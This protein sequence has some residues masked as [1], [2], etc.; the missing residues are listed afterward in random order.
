MIIMSGESSQEPA[1]ATVGHAAAVAPARPSPGPCATL[2][3]GVAAIPSPGSHLARAR[4]G[5]FRRAESGI[6]IE[7][8]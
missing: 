4:T 8:T 3:A 5:T 6:T 2:A 7:V 1:S